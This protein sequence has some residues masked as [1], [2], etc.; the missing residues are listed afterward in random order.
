MST[1]RIIGG[2][3][4]G[5]KISAPSNLPVRPTTDYAKEGLFNV[6]N[7]RIDFE[8]VKAL[9]LFAGTGNISYELASRGCQSITCVDADFRCI[10][11]IASTA[12]AFGFRQV[13]VV[14]S[15]VYSFLTK[16]K[17]QWDF[18]F[19]DPPYDQKDTVRL[20]EFVFKKELLAPG[21]LLIVE[22]PERMQFN[23]TSRLVETRSYG[24]V[25]FSFFA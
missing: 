22:H 25:N 15:D 17:G 21:G 20:P 23:D 2:E 19:A 8:S 13:K 16:A 14:R 6:L 7:N 1:L 3:F 4:K 9:D 18:I 10:K 5:R 24:K 12:E 11:F